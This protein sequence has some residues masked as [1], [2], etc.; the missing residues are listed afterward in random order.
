MNPNQFMSKYVTITNDGVLPVFGVRCLLPVNKL[1]DKSG[2]G[3]EFLSIESPDWHIGTMFPGDSYT[4]SPEHRFD[5]ASSEVQAAD[6][7]IAIS[8]IP[9]LPPVRMLKC[10]HIVVYQSSDG[11]E[12]WFQTPAS[13][14]SFPW[15]PGWHF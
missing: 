2:G 10:T 8:Y 12:H 9:V 7:G 6:F 13:C 5:F 11:Q 1:T 15:L 3:L 14:S 4:F